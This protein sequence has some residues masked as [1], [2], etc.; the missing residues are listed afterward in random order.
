MRVRVCSLC[1]GT[2]WERYGRGFVESFTRHWPADIELLL[3][4]D[5]VVWL[6]RGRQVE[7]QGIQ[8]YREFV[9]RWASVPV[10]NGRE[11]PEGGKVDASGYSWRHDAVKW[12]PQALAAIPGASGL[13][14]G[15]I[16]VWFD[17][18]TVTTAKVPPRWVEDLLGDA[19]VACLA[20]PG[21]HT[22]IGFYAMRMS[23][24]TRRVLRAFADLYI[25]DTIFRLS[26]QHSA[27][28]WD[29]AIETQPGLIVRNLNTR[30]GRGHVWPHTVLAEF[31]EHRKGKRKDQ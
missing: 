15:D 26:E 23:D 24:R 7:L 30:G 14:D 9:E 3:V 28:A 4:T 31:T 16:F 17:A 2:A 25:D 29:R 21:K 10:A 11:R 13:E 27:F 18:D 1:W 22:E 6:T 19:D 20:R 8:G 12:M 5:D